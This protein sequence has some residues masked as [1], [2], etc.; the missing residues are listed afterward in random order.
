MLCKDQIRPGH[1]FDLVPCYRSVGN[2][3]SR[4]LHG[5]S[6]RHKVLPSLSMTCFIKSSS[7]TVSTRCEEAWIRMLLG[8]SCVAV[9]A[10]A[11]CQWSCV[12]GAE[13]EPHFL[14]LCSVRATRRNLNSAYTRSTRTPT[15]SCPTIT[16]PARLQLQS[17]SKQEIRTLRLS[18]LSGQLELDDQELARC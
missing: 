1:D 9:R 18:W 4:K 7:G 2:D 8:A 6:F 13:T 17:S 3:N 12:S 11:L 15:D 5:D 10:P 16:M 14:L